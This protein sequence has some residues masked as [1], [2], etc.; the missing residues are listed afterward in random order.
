MLRLVNFAMPDEAWERS[1]NLWLRIGLLILPGPPFIGAG[2]AESL[3]AGSRPDPLHGKMNCPVETNGLA[4]ER[5]S[6]GTVSV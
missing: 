4:E 2:W 5:L 1:T 3:C 6:T